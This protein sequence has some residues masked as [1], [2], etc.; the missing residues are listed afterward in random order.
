[1]NEIEKY[2]IYMRGAFSMLNFI[3]EKYNNTHDLNFVD[4]IEDKILTPCEH[5]YKTALDLFYK[6]NNLKDKELT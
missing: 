6:A 2:E 5:Q 4:E 3:R 1:M